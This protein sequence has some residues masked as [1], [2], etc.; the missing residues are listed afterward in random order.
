MLM[1]TRIAAAEHLRW[2]HRR[3]RRRGAGGAAAVAAGEA[4]AAEERRR[5][6]PGWRC[7]GRRASA[8]GSSRHSSWQPLGSTG[9]KRAKGCR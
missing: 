8:T 4:A 7:A 1:M 9:G 5:P 3:R 6:R 2:G